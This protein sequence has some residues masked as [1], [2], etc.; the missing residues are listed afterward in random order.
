MSFVNF[1]V[2]LFKDLFS[3]RAAYLISIPIILWI[4]LKVLNFLR[5][6]VSIWLAVKQ[7]AH[8]FQWWQQSSSLSLKEK[9]YLRNKVLCLRKIFLCLESFLDRGTDSYMWKSLLLEEKI[10]MPGHVSWSRKCL[11]KV[12]EFPKCGKVI[13]CSGV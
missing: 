5:Y 11:I 4:F 13:R 2:W 1:R 10:H 9:R 12:E 6:W 3:L 8:L 7:L